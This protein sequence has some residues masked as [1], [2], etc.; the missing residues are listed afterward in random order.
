V[1]GAARTGTIIDPVSCMTVRFERRAV[2]IGGDRVSYGVAG[3]GTPLVLI[4][5]LSGSVRWWR[6]ILPAL[7]ERHRVYAVNLPGFGTFTGRRR[8]RP[9]ADTAGWL[10]EWI[11]ALGIRRV[12]L[13]GHSMGGAIAIRLSLAAPHLVGHL[14]LMNAAGYPTVRRLVGYAGPLLREARTMRRAFL[15]VLAVDALRAG[16]ATL[17]RT[18]GELL[19]EDIRPSLSDLR[20]PTLLVWGERDALVPLSVGET[21]QREIPRSRLVVISDAG[22][23][24][25]YDQPQAVAGAVLPF[26][27]T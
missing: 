9:L 24:P 18:A 20:G 21:L 1:A 27:D 10:R 12:D 14:V 15:P 7:A 2:D 26:L 23:V 22:H 17:L 6:P 11:E 16:P 3:Q 4:H 13:I 5:G 8:R 19:A 25:M